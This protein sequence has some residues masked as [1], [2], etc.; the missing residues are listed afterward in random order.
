MPNLAENVIIVGPQDH[1]KCALEL[2][3]GLCYISY[4]EFNFLCVGNIKIW[5]FQSMCY[6]RIKIY[7][8]LK[9]LNIIV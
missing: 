5:L 1:M 7:F 9:K 2:A 6:S 8:H 4:F 3:H